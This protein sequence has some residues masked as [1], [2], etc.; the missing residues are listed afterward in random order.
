MNHKDA[1]SSIKPEILPDLPVRKAERIAR[2]SGKAEALATSAQER[3]RKYRKALGDTWGHVQTFARMLRSYARRQYT[4]VPWKTIAL[5]TA[6]LLYFIMPFDAL[7]DFL[8]GGFIDD[9]AILAAVFRQVRTELDAFLEWE[10]TNVP[11]P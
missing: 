2:D 6:A 8:F 4:K 3:A 10:R 5:V 1:T 11:V 7:P 9:A